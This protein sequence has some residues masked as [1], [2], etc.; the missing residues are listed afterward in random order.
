MGQVRTRLSRADREEQ[1]VAAA[2]VLFGERGYAGATMDDVAQAVGVTKPLLYNYFGNKERLFLA[3]LERSG[4]ALAATI[5]EAVTATSSP[6]DALRAGMRAFFAF[7]DADR[8]GW[9]VLFDET[10][11]AAGDIALRASG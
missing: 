7:V 8:A 4:D 9:S 11:P 1:L 6:T 3:C 10:L 2:R 5:G